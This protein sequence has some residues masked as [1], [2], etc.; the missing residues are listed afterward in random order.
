MRASPETYRLLISIGL[1]AL[2]RRVAAIDHQ[3]AAGHELGFVGSEI[4]D[5]V[6]DVVWLA[7]MTNRVPA[8]EFAPE[9]LQPS[10]ELRASSSTSDK[11]RVHGVHADPLTQ[12]AGTGKLWLRRIV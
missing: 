10:G 11:A 9:C 5:A 4:D 3:F 8:I 12:A 7:D 6:G 2:S 1:R